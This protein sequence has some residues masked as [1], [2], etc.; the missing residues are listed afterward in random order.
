MASYIW[1][2]DGNSG[3][4]VSLIARLKTSVISAPL[5]MFASVTVYSIT[6]M[7]NKVLAAAGS[8]MISRLVIYGHAASGAQCVGCGNVGNIAKNK[9]DEFLMV[10]IA[11]GKLM[12]NAEQ[13]LSRLV[14][15]LAHDARVSLGGCKVATPPDGETLLKRLSVVLGVTVEGGMWDQRPFFAGY[16]GPVIRCNGNICSNI[17]GPFKEFR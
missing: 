4:L 10:A 9:K 11:D 1:A 16:E 8:D 3:D 2:I 12:N 7:V 15:K 14:P 17:T 6:D 5:N 13:A